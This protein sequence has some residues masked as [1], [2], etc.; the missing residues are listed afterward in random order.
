MPQPQTWDQYWKIPQT[1]DLS[2]QLSFYFLIEKGFKG[3]NK[4]IT[5][6]E[7]DV[8]PG[9][10]CSWF[11]STCFCTFPWWAQKTAS[12]GNFRWSTFSSIV[13]VKQ[14]QLSVCV[15]GTG[16]S[17]CMSWLLSMVLSFRVWMSDLE[18]KEE[19]GGIFSLDCSTYTPVNAH[20]K[21]HNS[22]CYLLV[23]YC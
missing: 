20:G 8:F 14:K 21:P 12:S 4:F 19:T 13:N 17:L 23:H 6:D 11:W 9:Y 3:I 18:T 5:F 1:W 16:G 10:A 22:Q 2:C 15:W 7:F